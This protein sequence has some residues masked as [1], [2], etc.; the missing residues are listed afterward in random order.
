[1]KTV[2]TCLIRFTYSFRFDFT[3]FN[4]VGFIMKSRRIVVGITKT[5]DYLECL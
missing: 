1:M 2:E 3:F 5:I 4:I